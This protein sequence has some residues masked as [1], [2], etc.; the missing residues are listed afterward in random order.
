MMAVRK[1]IPRRKGRG[2]TCMELLLQVACAGQFEICGGEPLGTAWMASKGGI[3][4]DTIGD[5]VARDLDVVNADDRPA[6]TFV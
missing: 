2:L 1:I 6:E 4:G 3:G 5:G